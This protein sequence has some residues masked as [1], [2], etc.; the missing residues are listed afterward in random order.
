MERTLVTGGMGFIGSHLLNR[1]IPNN[2]IDV[3]DNFANN[4]INKIE[5]GL[6]KVIEPL[7]LI[8]KAR[9]VIT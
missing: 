6:N 7:E 2:Q 8:E 3:L 5:D 9:E 1:L 4:A